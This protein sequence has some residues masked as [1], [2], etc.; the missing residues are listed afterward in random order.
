MFY[1]SV[2]EV[3]LSSKMSYKPY[4]SKNS[5]PVAA[6]ASPRTDV[7]IVQ[8]SKPKQPSVDQLMDK[9]TEQS[10]EIKR[11][12]TF[13]DAQSLHL[14]QIQENYAALEKRVIKNEKANIRTSSLFMV[15]DRVIDELT[16][17]L[18]KMQQYTRR[19][20]V[21]IAG[22]KKDKYEK[23]DD[24]KKEIHSLIEKTDGVVS[25]DDVDKFHRDGP[26]F[27]SKQDVILRFKSH[28]AKEAFYNN[29]KKIAGENVKIRPSLTDG[30][31]Q[32]MK[33]TNEATKDY[34]SLQNP[35]EFVLPDI[36]GN[37]LMK[38]KN[39][40]RLGLF[41]KFRNMETFRTNVLLAQHTDEIDD[42]FDAY[43]VS[44]SEDEH[45]IGPFF[46]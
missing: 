26:Q 16:Q 4:N 25:T 14:V 28:A 23:Y 27:G 20:S 3:Y 46:S 34:A 44:S 37:L 30:T 35:P 29:R 24:L 1:C 2:L 39:R 42:A 19:Y 33:A 36:H 13:V 9:I 12:R 17:Q 5:T 22:L 11:L 8:K 32:L 21:S 7:K 38:M 15:K 45:A 10:E 31:K 6:T 41:V 18:N 40:S 43:D